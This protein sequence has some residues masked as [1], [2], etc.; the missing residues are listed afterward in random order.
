MGYYA[1]AYQVVWLLSQGWHGDTYGIAAS[2]C[3]VALYVLMAFLIL[4]IKD[5]L[6]SL[7]HVRVF[8]LSG[9]EIPRLCMHQ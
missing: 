4:Q 2:A 7:R 9:I 5:V 3:G 6:E 1:V 8:R